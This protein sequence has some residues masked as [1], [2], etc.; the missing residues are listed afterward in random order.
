V[1]KRCA[2]SVQ[3]QEAIH[4]GVSNKQECEGDVGAHGQQ[5]YRGALADAM[6]VCYWVNTVPE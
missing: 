2:R 5:R 3:H 6:P 4:N 1:L